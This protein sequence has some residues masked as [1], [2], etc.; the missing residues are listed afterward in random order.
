MNRA[1]CYMNGEKPI[2]IYAIIVSFSGNARKIYC[3]IFELGRTPLQNEY[4]NYLKISNG[5]VNNTGVG[6]N[7]FFFKG[8]F[9]YFVV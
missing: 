1:K 2:C 8:N 5:G 3:D 7:T 9:V 6:V 4:R